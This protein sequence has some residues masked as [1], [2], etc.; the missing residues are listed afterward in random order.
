MINPLDNLTYENLVGKNLSAVPSLNGMTTASI[1]RYIPWLSYNHE[2]AS[3]TCLKDGTPYFR[4]YSIP[5]YET[6]ELVKVEEIDLGFY[7]SEINARYLYRVIYTYYEHQYSSSYPFYQWEYTRA[8]FRHET[9]RYKTVSTNYKWERDLLSYQHEDLPTQYINLDSEYLELKVYMNSGIGAE[10]VS[11]SP[12]SVII[13]NETIESIDNAISIAIV[14]EKYFVIRSKANKQI[15]QI[16]SDVENLETGYITKRLNIS[17]YG[18]S[19]DFIYPTFIKIGIKGEFIASRFYYPEGDIEE[20]EAQLIHKPN[21]TN[22]KDRLV[23]PGVNK[24]DPNFPSRFWNYD[25][26]EPRPISTPI[27]SISLPARIELL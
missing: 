23:P 5:F 4:E 20:L 9:L 27:S 2:I 26:I 16:Y 22:I 3:N 8:K 6:D 18:D 14:G 12:F 1:E 7:D 10:V 13:G 17:S 11:D 25:G 21:T 24:D 19:T 15:H